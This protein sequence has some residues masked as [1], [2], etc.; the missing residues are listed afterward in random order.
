MKAIAPAVVLVYMVVAM[1]FVRRKSE[2]EQ[3]HIMHM[4]GEL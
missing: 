2:K 4:R 1:H 3:R